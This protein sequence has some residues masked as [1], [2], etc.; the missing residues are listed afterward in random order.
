MSCLARQNFREYCS[1]R[2]GGRH[3]LGYNKSF[4]GKFGAIYCHVGFSSSF[5]DVLL[6]AV[7]RTLGLMMTLRFLVGIHDCLSV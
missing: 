1:H 7:F 2:Y 3:T 4:I 5:L 6:I